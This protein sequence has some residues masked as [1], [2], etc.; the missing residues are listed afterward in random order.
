MRLGKFTVLLF[1]L[2]AVCLSAF[3]QN[4]TVSVKTI[5]TKTIKYSSDYPFEK[6][7]LHLD[8]PYYAVGDTIWFKAYLTADI[9]ANDDMIK[10]K[11]LPSPISKVVYVDILTS[12]D[13]VVQRLKLPVTASMAYGDIKLLKENY[14]EGNYHIRAYTNWM[15]NFDPDYFF[16]KTVSVGTIVDKNVFSTI[17]LSG[18]TKGGTAKVSAIIHYYTVDGRDYAARKVSW[19][20][21]TGDDETLGKGKGTTDAKGN[22]EISFTT[23]KTSELNTA[24]LYAGIDINNNTI[25]NSYTLKNVAS[26]IDVQFFPEGGDLLNG[27]KSRVAFKA[28]NPNGLGAETKGVIVD[29]SGTTVAT[30]TTQHLGMGIFELTPAAG[31]TYKANLTFV[32]GSQSSYDLPVAKDNGMTL[33]INNTNADNLQITFTASD[34]FFAANQNK[35]IAVIGQ[36]GQIVC[37]A[38][39]TALTS[40]AYAASVPKAKFPSG[41][42]QFTV[43]SSTGLALAER[44]VFI[45][46][47][48]QL[49][50]S[51][52]TPKTTYT[53]RDQV[54][55]NV[56]AKTPDNQP[57]LANMSVTVLDETK[58]PFNENAETTI[59][60]NI[61]LTSDLKGY[62]EKPNYYFNKINE[63]TAADLDILMLTQGYRR[64]IYK[65]ILE[66]KL[67]TFKFGPEDGLEVT[68]SLRTGSGMPV[69]NGIVNFYIK[70]MRISATVNTN[71]DGEFR[72]SKLFFP[73]SVKGVINAKGNFNANN[74]MIILNNTTP[75][76]I[77][78]NVAAPDEIA[79]IDTALN[80]YLQNDK[81]QELNSHVIKEVVVKDVRPPKKASHKDY[82][83]LTGLSS[84]PDH[85]IDGDRFTACASLYDCIKNSL[86]GITYDNDLLYLTRNY[87]SGKKVEVSIYYDGAVV[88]LT[89]L[90]GVDPKTIDQI[91]VYNSDGLSGINRMNNTDGVIVISS[92]KVEKKPLDKELLKELTTPQ[93][94]AV[95]FNPKGYYLTREFYSPKYDATK[96]GALGGDLRTTIYW[97]PKVITN[98]NGAA[99]FNF[100]NA[101]GT[102]SY[103]AI[104]EGIDDKGNVGR[105]VYKY[106]V[107]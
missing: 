82:P 40:K 56:N 105:T 85:V 24:R 7:Y 89:R 8:K 34:A 17:S 1:L 81:K 90:G 33:A 21:Q 71:K 2:L 48:D 83:F 23:N 87:N 93:Y 47:N 10:N 44:L 49:K 62:I 65:D 37:Y 4:D 68:G 29:N 84:I 42:V 36:S 39:Q 78:P 59:L 14:N 16:N 97:N 76:A 73:D 101:D 91:E 18:Q 77:T 99:T 31:K 30:I 94:S 51:L 35:Q 9:T 95:K 72:I 38:G 64:V 92:K 96:T 46:R 5:A 55:F 19:R 52:S 27:I 3:S 15:R 74:L 86:P 61:L 53:A 32:D 69:S 66:N 63:K 58:V 70:D 60:T 103:K 104:I 54:V 26:P 79:N 88:D 22:I 11:H 67:P 50:I 80:S 41:V 57:A 13:S 12:K 100:F 6:V 43:F 98:K 45:Q 25:T 106:T 20:A 75:Q 102:G 28:V 107:R